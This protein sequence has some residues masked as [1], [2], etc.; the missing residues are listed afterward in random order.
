MNT[1]NTILGKIKK[2]IIVK[3]KTGGLNT[4]LKY[5]FYMTIYKF[6]DITFI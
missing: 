2:S 4:N 1:L 5:N 3:L 6:L